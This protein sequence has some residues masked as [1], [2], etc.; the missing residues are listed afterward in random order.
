MEI[1]VLLKRLEIKMRACYIVAA[2]FIA[3]F[4]QVSFAAEKIAAPGMACSAVS[5]QQIEI[6][7]LKSEKIVKVKKTI[8][9]A[10]AREMG[11]T[12]ISSAVQDD[13]R[14]FLYLQGLIRS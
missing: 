13:M 9:Q 1:L 12:H 5:V 4:G 6:P 10:S 2:S 14:T 3:L 7:K 8:P 11:T